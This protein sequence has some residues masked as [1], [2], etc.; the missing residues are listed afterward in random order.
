M[1]YIF[2]VLL[3]FFCYATFSAPSKST[4]LNTYRI[5]EADGKVG[6]TDDEGNV[7]IPAEYDHIGWS[8]GKLI[9]VNNTIGYRL[10][11]VWGLIS[12]KNQK[13]TSSLFSQLYHAG[14]GM[15]VAA[16]KGKITKHDFLGLIS[17]QGKEILPFKYTSID[18]NGLRAI[19][20]TK[21]A[22]QYNYGVVD[23]TNKIVIPIR[24]KEVKSLGG[25]RFA[26]KNEKNKSA[27]Y[28]DR[29]D[30]LMDFKLDSISP[31]EKGYARVYQ[32]YKQGL[33][34]VTG[35][36]AV[37]P[38]YQS[39]KVD[40][41]GAKVKDFNQWQT[42]NSENKVIDSWHYDGLD[43]YAETLYLASANGKYWV[44][45]KKGEALSSIDNDFV[46]PVKDGK[47]IFRKKKKWG[48]I[49]ENGTVL[50]SATFDSVI[51]DRD[52]VYTMM[53]DKGNS[54]WSMYDTFGV[55][56]SIY[57][58]DR[59]NAKT[60]NLYPVLRKKYW[61][62]I[63]RT[64][65]EVIHCVYD[66]VGQFVDNHVA[67]K[68]HGQY[69]IL[70]KYGEWKVLPQSYPLELINED[71]YLMKSPKITTL[72]S[73]ESGTIYFTENEIEVKRGYLL[74]HL[75][76][77]NLWKID[78]AGRIVNESGSANKSRYEE[79]RPPSEGFYGAKINGAYGFIDDRNRLRI[80]NRYED[81]GTFKEGL[82]AIKLRNKWGFI[83]KSETLVIQPIYD[84]KSD[85]IGNVAIVQLNDLYGIIDKAGKA[86]I[87]PEYNHIEQLSNG[88]FLI[89]KDKRYGLL[90]K[91]GRLIINVKYESLEDLDNGQVIVQ[92]FGQF[93]VV[94]LY[95]VDVIP[96]VYDRLKF[97][98][99]FSEYL[100]MK[101]SKWGK[102]GVR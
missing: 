55:K 77:G 69:G 93:G 44:V 17:T 37:E 102:A 18:V 9:P 80:A 52:V 94:D 64:G 96:I 35:E 27:I 6:M 92:K 31:F 47:S 2:S 34:K 65:E 32:N 95:G 36:L 87:K 5:F 13:I 38:I 70:D 60:K 67:V 75:A 91:D 81:V 86:L 1:K 15:L 24:Y 19:V 73:I 90:D 33:I 41:D 59:I 74:E 7:I 49:R 79:I 57:N 63:D 21:N 8:K 16:K 23:F 51:V 62:F 58:Y 99:R 68:F 4:S 56:K 46:S 98:R 61:G 30:Q 78:F 12:L 43:A 88:R 72:K 22:H 84:E 48:V 101:K 20:S 71:L 39:V 76:D 40:D 83:N 29:G 42:L 3:L 89:R 66:E 97:D 25:L 53:L 10:A 54:K 45:D 50:M 26:V 82:A 85:F 11:G 28:S 100:A 14:G